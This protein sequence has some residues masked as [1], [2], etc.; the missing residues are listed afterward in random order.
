MEN[1]KELLP[2]FCEQG[3]PEPPN[4]IVQTIGKINGTEPQKAYTKEGFLGRGGF[5]QCHITYNKETDKRVATK[6]IPKT[7]LQA[8]RTKLRVHPC[9]FPARQ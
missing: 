7:L 2:N 6:I 1:D 9:L 4:E 8:A 3:L 5:A